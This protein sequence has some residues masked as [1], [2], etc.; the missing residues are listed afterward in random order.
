MHRCRRFVLRWFEPEL[1]PDLYRIVRCQWREYPC[2]VYS[3][4]YYTAINTA[5]GGGSCLIHVPDLYRRR[6]RHGGLVVG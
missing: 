4:Y 6:H 3:E 2:G 1:D 5:L